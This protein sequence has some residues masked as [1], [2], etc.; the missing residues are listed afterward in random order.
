MMDAES[1]GFD[2]GSFDIVSCRF[3]FHHFTNPGKVMS[4]MVRVCKSG[5]TIVLVDGLSSEDDV[6]SKYHNEI[7][8]IRDP[9]HVRLYQQSELEGM[10]RDAGLKM[11]HAR[12]WDADFYFDEWISIAD[13]GDEIV[14]QLRRTM[15]DSIEDDK[16]GLNVHFDDAGR[17]LFTHDTVILVAGKRWIANH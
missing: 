10:F 9:S 12:N 6:K 14:E 4:E 1:L 13:P 17:L 11:I 15:I 3:A 7:E 2:D 8:Q 5:G 16:T